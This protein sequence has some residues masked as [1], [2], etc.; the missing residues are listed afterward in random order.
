MGTESVKHGSKNSNVDVE[1]TLEIVRALGEYLWLDDRNEASFLA[2][3]S[4][5]SQCVCIHLRGSISMSP[6]LG[7]IYSLVFVARTGAHR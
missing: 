3:C 1:T 5:A 2:D 6:K 4:I 7:L